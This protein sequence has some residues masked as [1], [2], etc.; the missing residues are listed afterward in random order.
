MNRKTPATLLLMA[1]MLLSACNTVRGAGQDIQ[2]GGQAISR[3]AAQVQ[4][5]LSN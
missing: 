4:R 2:A 3:G 1:A 5:E